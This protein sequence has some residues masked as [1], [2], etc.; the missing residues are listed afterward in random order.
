MLL[1]YFRI[2]IKLLYIYM[3]TRYEIEF[4]KIDINFFLF[5]LLKENLLVK[6]LS[7]GKW[8][9]GQILH[10]IYSLPHSNRKSKF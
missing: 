5:I 4:D 1:W 10:L 3:Y 8:K 7:V 2:P 6:L 9:R